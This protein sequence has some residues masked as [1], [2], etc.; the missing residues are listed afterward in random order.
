MCGACRVTVGGTTKVR[1]RRRPEFDGHQVDFKELVMRNRAYLREEKTA[2]ERTS[3]RTGTAWSPAP[4]GRWKLMADATRR[5]R[6]KPSASP[7]ADAGA[8]PQVR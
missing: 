3:I 1:L 8:A 7:A 2:M 5:P 4:R 6:P